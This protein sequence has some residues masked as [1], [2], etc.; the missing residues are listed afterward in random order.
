MT[1]QPS[2]LRLQHTPHRTALL[3]GN[4]DGLLARLTPVSGGTLVVFVDDGAIVD[5]E[6]VS[7]PMHATAN[8]LFELFGGAAFTYRIE[9]P[10]ISRLA[11]S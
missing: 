7:W 2:P 3:I 10:P 6:I 4:E 11:P 9:H 8:A 1:P 5:A